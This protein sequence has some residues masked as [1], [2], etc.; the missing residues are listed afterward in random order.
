MSTL[1]K[2]VFAGIFA[3]ALPATASAMCPSY[4][5]SGYGLS[6]DAESAYAPQSTQVI[7]GGDIDLGECAE[8]PGYGYVV[9]SPDFTMQYDALGMGRALELRANASCDA[10]LLINTAE[11]EWLFNDDTNELNPAVRIENA[12][13]GQ[14]DI[15]VG[16]LGAENCE[17]V[18]EVETF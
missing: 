13:S 10:V 16:T 12:P 4:E 1:T 14:Y 17:A 2:T 9:E 5:T 15:W 7:A 8:L 18:F 3:L 11:G 6:Y